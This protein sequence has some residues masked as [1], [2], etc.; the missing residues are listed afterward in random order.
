[1]T[2]AEPRRLNMHNG[3]QTSF[4]FNHTTIAAASLDT[5]L[6]S[7]LIWRLGAEDHYE[8]TPAPSRDRQDS[9]LTSSF[10]FRF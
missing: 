2:T 3:V 7:R 5:T 6:N 8:S 1:M 10:A 4:F 9:Q